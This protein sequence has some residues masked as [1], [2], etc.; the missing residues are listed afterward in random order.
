MDET[1]LYRI[2]YNGKWVKCVRMTGYYHMKLFDTP[3]EVE[4]VRLRKIKAT[5]GLLAEDN[6]LKSTDF[7]IIEA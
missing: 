7:E 2:K 3:E 6:N 5:I 1:K 4:P